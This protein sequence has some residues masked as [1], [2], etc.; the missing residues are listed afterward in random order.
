MRLIPGIAA[1][2]ALAL[3]LSSCS[4]YRLIRADD[5]EIPSYEPREVP[6]PASCDPLIRR[7]AE[8]GLADFTESEVR[9]L[10]FCQQQYVIRAQEEEAASEKL[11]AHADAANFA[12][13][14]ATVAISVLAV[15]V[16]WAF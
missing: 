5:I 11:E 4:G 2:L 6:I 9:E 16:A 12:L 1:A 8:R 14:V 13:N 7:A 10:N 3:P 15:I